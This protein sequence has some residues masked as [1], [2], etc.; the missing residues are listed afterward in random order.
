MKYNLYNMFML[1]YVEGWMCVCSWSH[2]LSLSYFFVLCFWVFV[3]LRRVLHL[4]TK[5]LFVPTRIYYLI[6]L[7]ALSGKKRNTGKQRKSCQIKVKT[8]KNKTVSF[9]GAG[10]QIQYILQFVKVQFKSHPGSFFVSLFKLGFLFLQSKDWSERY[11]KHRTGSII[12]S[13]ELGWDSSV[14]KVWYIIHMDPWTFMCEWN[15]YYTELYCGSA[16]CKPHIK[17]LQLHIA[18]YSTKA[19]S[20]WGF[21]INQIHRIMQWHIY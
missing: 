17:H 8:N 3:F 11:W 6:V 5:K 12:M 18:L 4:Q 9:W 14:V 7:T 16:G 10:W 15:T 13:A 1:L 2:L 20:I 21:I 19:W